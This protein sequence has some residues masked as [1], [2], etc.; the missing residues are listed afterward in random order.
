[1]AGASSN[2]ELVVNI[3]LVFFQTIGTSVA[4]HRRKIF[5]VCSLFLPSVKMFLRQGLLKQSTGVETVVICASL[6][7]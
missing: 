6:T 2:T 5:K 3:P 1:M 7:C 4:T